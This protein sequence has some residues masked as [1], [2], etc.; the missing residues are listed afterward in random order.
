[1]GTLATILFS[2]ISAAIFTAIFS[3][4]LQYFRE[5]RRDK[6]L[7]YQT[8]IEDALRHLYSLKNWVDSMFMEAQILL[9][10]LG[11][12]KFPE[13]HKDYVRKM[14][15]ESAS[16]YENIRTLYEIYMKT[17]DLQQFGESFIS[18][19]NCFLNPHT[20]N[21]N[22]R[23]EALNNLQKN[24]NDLVKNAREEIQ[25]Y[26]AAPK[27]WCHKGTTTAKGNSAS[28]RPSESR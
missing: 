12:E 27:F 23:L 24:C 26:I 25:P 11:T 3:Q 20:S 7:L 8:K 15:K 18:F 9:R 2:A 5:R 14:T 1:M 21:D 22:Q 17:S 4:W 19:K 28:V 10:S 16:D 13:L 6:I